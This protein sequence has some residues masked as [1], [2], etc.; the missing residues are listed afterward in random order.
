MAKQTKK[1]ETK[2][3]A[4]GLAPEENCCSYCGK[5]LSTKRGRQIHEATCEKRPDQ[6]KP[7]PPVERGAAA[8]AFPPREQLPLD[9]ELIGTLVQT[10]GHRFAQMGRGNHDHWEIDK[11][12]STNM[13][14]SWHGWL[15]AKWPELPPT[16]RYLWLASLTTLIVLGFRLVE[17][18]EILIVSRRDV[19]RREGI[20]PASD[21][22]RDS[23]HG[24]DHVSP[25][26][27]EGVQESPSIRPPG[28]DE[29]RAAM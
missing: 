16:E 13:A 6:S 1:K 7:S 10:I 27:P 2:N 29:A 22:S 24:K 23:G 11:I 3:G 4:A 17:T 20:T 9:P 21:D 18:L 15:E 25:T 12:E 14:K 19:S 5:V 26:P 8:E 28:G